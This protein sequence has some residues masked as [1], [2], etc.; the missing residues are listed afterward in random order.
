MDAVYEENLGAVD[1]PDAGDDALIEKR[2]GDRRVARAQAL[3]DTLGVG[4]RG[5]RIGPQTGEDCGAFLFR[6]DLAGGRTD[7]IPGDVGSR[8]THP[9]GRARCRRGSY[10]SIEVAEHSKMDVDDRPAA[11]V[12][13]EVLAARLGALEDAPIEGASL[14]RKSLLRR[15]DADAPAGKVAVVLTSE[16]VDHV[17]LGHAKDPK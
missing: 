13:E 14:S 6:D 16:P 9:D 3:E 17:S 5:E 12:V 8:E 11:P 15:R 10:V 1:V 4:L 2:V 7:Q